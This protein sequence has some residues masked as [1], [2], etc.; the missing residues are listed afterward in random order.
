[1]DKSDLDDLSPEAKELLKLFLNLPAWQRT[2]IAN[3]LKGFLYN[4]RGPPIN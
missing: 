1:M 2:V 3:F 4:V